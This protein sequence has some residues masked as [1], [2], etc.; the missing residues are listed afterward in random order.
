M[1]AR[2]SDGISQNSIARVICT[3][4]GTY[5]FPDTIKKKL[6]QNKY[7][8]I[9]LLDR[10]ERI[11][12]EFIHD[13]S[14]EMVRTCC[15]SDTPQNVIQQSNMNTLKDAMQSFFELRGAAAYN[16]IMVIIEQERHILAL[17]H[18]DAAAFRNAVSDIQMLYQTYY[19]FEHPNGK[20]KFDDNKKWHRHVDHMRRFLDTYDK[21]Q[22]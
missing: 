9:F 8:P 4:Y 11:Y 22:A 20:M 3:L 7:P 18:L 2:N 1:R 21:E 15:I 10:D 6:K 13:F 19:D 16:R 5:V 12:E 17:E 14:E